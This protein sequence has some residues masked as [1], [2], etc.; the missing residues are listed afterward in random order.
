MD[1]CAEK[2][3]LAEEFTRAAETYA[4]A[5]KDLRTVIR[6]KVPVLEEIERARIHC[7]KAR[8]ALHAH[9]VKHRC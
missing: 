6:D 8:R 2:A 4:K 5:A 1:H 7:Q 3:R 9:M